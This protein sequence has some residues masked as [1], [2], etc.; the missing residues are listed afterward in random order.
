M[1]RS[2]FISHIDILNNIKQFLVFRQTYKKERVTQK[3]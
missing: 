2:F 1:S 3:S